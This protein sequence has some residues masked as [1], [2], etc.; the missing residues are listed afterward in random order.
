MTLKKPNTATGGVCVVTSPAFPLI[1]LASLLYYGP[2]FLT[3]AHTRPYL[4]LHMHLFLLLK[5]NFFIRHTSSPSLQCLRLGCGQ[6]RPM[7]VFF[8][9]F[10]KLILIWWW[11]IILKQSYLFWS[12]VVLILL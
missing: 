6:D 7:T 12:I 10:L 11:S 3:F 1:Q 9:V 2:Y 4:I 5:F 8:F